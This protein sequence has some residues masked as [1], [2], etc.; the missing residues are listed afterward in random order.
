MVQLVGPYHV[1]LGPVLASLP[2]H[3]FGHVLGALVDE[4][5]RA[6]GGV[7][8]VAQ[9]R[10]VLRLGSR[11]GRIDVHQSTHVGRVDRRVHP[12]QQA[13]PGMADEHVGRLQADLAEQGV[14]PFSD[15]PRGR[16]ESVRV[17][18]A[19]ACPI[20]GDDC[21]EAGDVGQDG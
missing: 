13:A 4:L 21:R 20:V 2:A 15:V 10:E 18:A 6:V 1:H 9:V 5:S 7:A 12:D 11:I 19:D 17:R 3:E 16:R 8:A 14:E